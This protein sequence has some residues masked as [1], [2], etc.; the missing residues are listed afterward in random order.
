MVIP[1]SNPFDSSEGVAWR[2]PARADVFVRLLLVVALLHHFLKGAYPSAL[3]YYFPFCYSYYKIFVLPITRFLL[4]A[5]W[6]S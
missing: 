2:D 1:Q 4:L 6:T 5:V 3:Y